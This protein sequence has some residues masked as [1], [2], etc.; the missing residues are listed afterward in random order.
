MTGSILTVTAPAGATVTISKG[1]KT[2]T[3]VA[4]TDGAVVFRG[5]STGDWTLSITD[6]T[7]TAQKTVT[8]TT[9]YST[10]ITFF[11]ATIHV[12]YPAGST[13]TATDGVT[14]LTAPDTSGTWD[15]VVPNA[16]AWTVTI[17]NGEDVG[18]VAVEVQQETDYLVFIPDQTISWDLYNLTNS[19]AITDTTRAS[20][21]AS[22]SGTT[23]NLH[24]Q[25]SAYKELMARKAIDLTN[26]SQIILDATITIKNPSQPTTKTAVGVFSGKD[27]V[28][29]HDTG[30]VSGA[31]TFDVNLDADISALRGEYYIG[32]YVHTGSSSTA[33]YSTIV[34]KKC[35]LVR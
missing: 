12:I 19:T 18:S 30:Y 15:C 26:W 9:D 6:G 22:N 34:I 31:H 3:K 35:I 25:S 17:A 11:S 14:T 33:M 20:V 16:G 28:T 27:L 7:Q 10:A 1:D 21:D 29:G 4:G 32:A 8:I 24:P 2:R 13:C 23:I 5:L